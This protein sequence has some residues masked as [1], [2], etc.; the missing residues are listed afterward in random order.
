MGSKQ[1]RLCR[2]KLN[3][4]VVGDTGN[5]R[6]KTDEKARKT[7]RKNKI[8]KTKYNGGATATG[9]FTIRASVIEP[10]AAVN[11]FTGSGRLAAS[12][13]PASTC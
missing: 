12:R 7:Q 2:T 11:S 10:A 6:E 3:F 1:Q 8:K 4:S 9:G 13:S 5:L